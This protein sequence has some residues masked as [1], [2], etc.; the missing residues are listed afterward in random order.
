MEIDYIRQMDILPPDALDFAINIIGCGGI[1][2]PT[3]L[4]ICKMGARSLTLFDPDIVEAHN[5]PNQLFPVESIGQAKVLALADQIRRFSDCD[6]VPVQTAVGSEQ[7]VQLQGLCIVCT[8][9]MKA[10]RAVWEVIKDSP[11][12][13]LI[14]ARLGG[15]VALI[16]SIDPTNQEEREFYEGTLYRD[17]EALHLPCTARAIAYN[18]FFI[19]GL[20]GNLVKRYAMGEE[21]PREIIADLKLLRIEK[22]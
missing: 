11:V 5:I 3:A 13:R 8:D 15:E 4:A 20:I 17:E 18:A 12:F 21:V 16:Y 6:P 19:S 14:D 1:G 7:A 9:T 2:S 22:R 10:R